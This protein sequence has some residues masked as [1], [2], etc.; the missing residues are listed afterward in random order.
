MPGQKILYIIG[1][2]DLGGAE[3]HLALITP[4]LK[5]LG[6]QPL[7]YCISRRGVQSEQLERDG[8]TVIGPP[9]E[10]SASQPLVLKWIQLLASSIKFFVILLA[11]RPQIVHCVLPLAYV[12]GAPL[13]LIARVPKVVMSRRSLNFYQ[14]QHPFFRH[15]ELWLHT[16]VD[17]ILGNSRAVHD[18]LIELEGC[19]ERKVGII[20]NGID[21]AAIDRAL[22]PPCP[23]D[24]PQLRLIIVANLIPYKGHADLIEALGGIKDRLPEPWTLSCAGRDDGILKRLQDQTRRLDLERQVQFLGERTDVA[25]LLKSA[26]IGILCSHEE[27]FANVILEGMAAGL[28]MVVTDVGGNS[29]AVVDGETGLIVSTRNPPALAEAILKLATNSE[30]RQRM[31]AMARRRVAER[32]SIDACVGEYDKAYR[33]LIEQDSKQ[34]STAAD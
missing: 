11:Q 30:M 4:R 24:T 7:I 12:L 15:I 17:A 2:L 14:T 5:K 31:G 25:M 29:E 13:A 10:S 23:A 32:F 3:R 6:W 33:R 18:Q 19:D 34:D 28:P 26:D 21:I 16:R 27:G 20:Y 1:S 22:P 8:V 9:W